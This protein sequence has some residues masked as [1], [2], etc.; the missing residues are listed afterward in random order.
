MRREIFKLYTLHKLQSAICVKAHLPLAM[1]II[2]FSLRLM[3]EKNFKLRTPLWLSP[4]ICVEA[5][6][7]LTKGVITLTPAQ[8][9]EIFSSLHIAM[10]TI[11]NLLRST[12]ETPS[13]ATKFKNSSPTGLTVL[14]ATIRAE[15]QAPLCKRHTNFYHSRRENNLQLAWGTNIYALNI[16]I[17]RKATSRHTIH[18]TSA[19]LDK[20]T[21]LRI[22][23][24]S[25]NWKPISRGDRRSGVTF[26]RIHRTCALQHFF[27]VVTR[28]WYFYKHVLADNLQPIALLKKMIAPTAL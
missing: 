28:S 8:C 24:V 25:R 11:H 2:P 13:S 1:D 4:A 19:C 21:W 15:I 7:S 12:H 5:H 20:S 17:T 16:T 14:I 26:C 22:W 18:K 23:Y 6:L 9:V 10:N 27:L 3:R